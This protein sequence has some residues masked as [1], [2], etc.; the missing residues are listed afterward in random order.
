MAGLF[1]LKIPAQT[2]DW[3]RTAKGALG[4]FP[5]GISI[6]GADNIVSGGNFDG[7]V[8]FDPGPGVF[9]LV[10]NV[11]LGGGSNGHVFL[12]KLDQDG[13]F[14]WAVSWGDDLGNTRLNS[15]ATDV[16][17]NVYSIGTY[18]GEVDFDPS[19]VDS[20]QTQ[21][22]S[23]GFYIHKMDSNGNFVWVRTIGN[24]SQDQAFQIALDGEANLYIAGKFG[25]Y[26]D[27][28]PSV[29]TFYLQGGILHDSFLLKLT[30][31]GKF[32]WAKMWTGMWVN[33][34]KCVATDKGDGVFV[35]GY[36]G[37][38]MDM[39]PSPT[40]SLV[41]E[42]SDAFD[43]YLIRLDTLG[44]FQWA[45][46][47]GGTGFSRARDLAV[48]SFG[49]V[50]MAGG[51]SGEL[52]LEPD[53][54]SPTIDGIDGG[55]FLKKVD[56][57]GTVLWTQVWESTFFQEILALAVNGAGQVYAT[58]QFQDSLDLDPSSAV[59]ELTNAGPLDMFIMELDPSGNFQWGMNIAENGNNLGTGIAV[60]GSGDILA[61]GLYGGVVDFDPGNG[62]ALDSTMGFFDM[63][64]LKLKAGNLTGWRGK[65]PVEG[66]VYPNPTQGK[67]KLKLPVQP[68]WELVQ[69]FDAKGQLKFEKEV[70]E[71]G[72]T[73]VEIAG[74]A[75]VY[76][77]RARAIDGRTW[78]GKL[79]K[80]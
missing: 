12:Q 50:V 69:V 32:R 28:D 79:L 54:P 52:I 2:F 45:S 24:V 77:I 51:Y 25:G 76:L 17:G 46:R 35:S 1:A 55:F 64:V 44:N 18:E 53:L 7:T 23:R 6:D 68:V 30:S 75:G 58:G 39:D 37:G 47:V 14:E 20:F 48:D 42:A 73:E 29:N 67:A 10:S 78:Q 11:P 71:G 70:G 31:N 36:F 4:V 80:Q 16:D 15:L 19:P 74:P 59:F 21:P 60:D 33:E 63:Y 49:N 5:K 9:N 22:G 27:F 3:A 57:A 13:N 26:T 56:G 40:D 38:R 61:G 34:A 66:W 41:L 65:E 8:D 43:L 62:M 72:Y